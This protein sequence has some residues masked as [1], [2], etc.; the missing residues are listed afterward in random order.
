MTQEEKK[1]RNTKVP[2][3]NREISWLSF[4]DR[5]LQEA[6]DPTVPLIE[7]IKF[8]GIFSSNLDEFFRVRVASV[9]KLIKLRIKDKTRIGFSPKKLMNNIKRI[10]ISQ[11]AR[12]E[13]LFSE[14]L[15]D[16]LANEKIFILNEKQLNVA[17]GNFVREYFREK[18]LP[19][20]V[21]I[22]FDRIKEFP[23]LKD[24][25][26]YLVVRL[27]KKDK[28]LKQKHALIEIPAKHSRFL[29]LPETGPLKYLILLDDVIR[30][31][32]EDIFSIFKYDHYEAYTVKLTRDA[33]LDLD[34]EYSE[35]FL[36]HMSKSL[37]QRKKGQPVRFI[38]DSAIPKDL[39]A[40]LVRRMHIKSDSLIPG[41]RYHNFKDFMRFPH[42]GSPHL[43]YPPQEPLVVRELDL[44]G[45]MLAEIRQK[46]Y[47]LHFPYE[48]FDYIIH[49]LR[50]AAID[51]KVKSI[52]ITLYR[53]ADDS[54][55]INALINA[56]KNG[57]QITAIVELQARFDEENNINWAQLLEDEGV[58]V[59]YGVPNLKVHSKMCLVTRK[60]QN[61]LVHYANI[62]TGNLNEQT[63]KVYSDHSML[64]ANPKITQEV[65]R[66][67]RQLEKKQVKGIYKHLLVAPTE[68]RKK[69]YKLIDKEIFNALN[70]KEAYITMKMNNLVDEAMIYRLYV[71]SCAGVRIKLIIRGICCLVPNVRN[72][73]ENIEVISIIDRYLEHSR[74]YIFCNGG[75]E[76]VYI[77]SADLMTR[78][79]DHRVEV[80]VPVYDKDL[81]RELKNVIDLQLRDNTKARVINKQQNNKYK[82][83]RLRKN[84]RSQVDIYHYL[85]KINNL[86]L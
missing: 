78:N 25:A 68:M 86:R 4:N 11:Q 60:E 17:R 48:S 70:G 65:E 57:K 82:S 40:Y 33:E 47:L 23:F 31:C 26:I 19:T 49:F 27:S 20:L 74:V 61:K 63:A 24:H 50:E 56:A 41:G 80:A 2:F 69:I 32:L 58:K 30:Y 53:L 79:L 34:N 7:R 38:Y 35:S 21:P 62:A 1:L 55:V 84:Y 28:S 9:A 15:I 6:Y 51:P 43:H 76:L 66:L 37:K 18:I 44:Q 3:I 36:E 39:L 45:S 10:V 22:M 29:V 81:Q 64:T 71:A 77:S 52:K 72:F 12:F 67:F 13:K 16:E 46:D 73:S 85:K 42:M 75:D 5:V 14:I 83:S 59:L 8:I 54:R